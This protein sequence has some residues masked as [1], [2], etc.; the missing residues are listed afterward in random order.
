[1]EKRE[2]VLTEALEKNAEEI[3]KWKNYLEETKVGIENLKKFIKH[4]DVDVMVPV[5]TKAFMPGK[6]IH[7]N[8]I[9]VSHYQ[10]YFSKCSTNKAREICELRIENAKEH[11][12]KLEVEAELWQNKLQKPYEDGVLAVGEK[13]DIIEDY[14]EQKEEVWRG[15]HRERIRQAKLK[16]KTERDSV[17]KSDEEVFKM[18][19]E[20][21]LMEEL[22]QELDSLEINDMTEEIIN[23]LIS[24]DMKVPK[25]RN[26]ISHEKQ[27]EQVEN[28]CLRGVENEEKQGIVKKDEISDI[29]PATNNN[30][31]PNPELRTDN[32]LEDRSSDEELPEEIKIITEQAKFLSPFDQIG[33]Y[34][35]QLQIIRRKLST[36]PLKTPEQLDEKIRLLTVLEHLEDLLETAEEFDEG[37]TDKENQDSDIDM[38][39]EN[40]QYFIDNQSEQMKT[41]QKRRISFALEDETLEFRKNETVTQMK[42]QPLRDVIQLDDVPIEN[43]VRQNESSIENKKDLI[44]SRVEQ[45]LQFIEEN[46]SKQD[47]NMV[48]QILKASMAQIKTFHIKFQHSTQEPKHTDSKEDDNNRSETYADLPGTPADFYNRYMKSLGKENE[49]KFLYLDSYAGEDQ[50]KAPILKEVDR[51]EAFQDPKLEF[52]R[53]AAKVKSILRNKKAVKV[54]NHYPDSEVTN[55]KSKTKLNNKSAS[56]DDEEYMSAYNKVMNDVM[57]KPLIDPEPLPKGKFIDAHA[58]KK[59]ISRFKQMR[60]SGEE[61]V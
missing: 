25:E 20:A 36:L 5:G 30:I 8:E 61:E 37:N 32:Q 39:N 50:V 4:L 56:F 26:R 13:R 27:A 46:Q 42:I 21:E 11:L 31:L 19:E 40:H 52:S 10:G 38:T 51:E 35:Y 48:E 9:L 55:K 6:L 14:D 15:Q 60:M 41:S 59:R 54:E 23:K 16:E 12:K 29:M 57:E 43:Q 44:K 24:G 49:L 34:D 18:L 33:F 2:S 58:P 47:F 22:E 1:M 17:Q 28:N 45:N 53:P 3:E 7:T